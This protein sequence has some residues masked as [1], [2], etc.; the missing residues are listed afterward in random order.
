MNKAPAFQFYP[1]D[2][3]SD[4]TVAMMTHEER[5]IYITLLCHCWLEGSIPAEEAKLARLIRCDGAALTQVMP[6]FTKSETDDSRLV[7]PRLERVRKAQEEHRRLLSEAGKRGGRPRVL[8][9][10]KAGY[11]QAKAGPKPEKALHSSSSDSIDDIFTL[12]RRSKAPSVE[13]CKAEFKRF[14]GTDEMAAGFHAKHESREW[15]DGQT[16]IR[17]WRPLVCRFIA[18][19]RVAQSKPRSNNGA[20]IRHDPVELDRLRALS[21]PPIGHIE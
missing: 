15:M 3:L 10:M 9:A 16:P 18:N 20:R 21:I 1:G 6:A 14:G 2:F 13:D 5:G 7:N 4:E 8:Q 12:G 19:W 17:N 11:R